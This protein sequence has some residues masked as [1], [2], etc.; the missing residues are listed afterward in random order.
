MKSQIGSAF[1][2]E[3]LRPTFHSVAKLLLGLLTIHVGPGK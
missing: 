2:R 1:I 3:N